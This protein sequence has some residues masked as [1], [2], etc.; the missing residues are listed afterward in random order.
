MTSETNPKDINLSGTAQ[1]QSKLIQIAKIE[2]KNLILSEE[3][4]NRLETPSWSIFKGGNARKSLVHW[5]GRE[6]EITQIKQ[7]FNDQNVAMIGIKGVG[8]IGKSTLASKIFEE[9]I[10][11]APSL[12]DDEDLF[13]KRFWWEAGNLG[14]FSGLAR[15]FLTDFGYPVP[16]KEIDLQEA[17]IRQLQRYSHLIIIDNLESL[18]GKDGSWNNEFYQQFFTAW[19]E[20]GDTSKIIVT[21]REKPKTRGFNR[22]IELKGLKPPEGAQLLAESQITGDLENFSRRVDGHPL[23]LRLVADLILAEFPQNPSLERLADLGLGNL[24]Q[25]LSD[26]QVMGSH[27]QETVGIALVLDASFQRLSQRQQELFTKTSIYRR[28]FDSPAAKAVMD[29]YPEIALSEITADLR[30]LQRRSLLEE[31]EENRQ[32]IFSFQPLVWEYAQYKA[33]DQREL[34]QK[35]I[36][37]YL[38]IAKPDSWETLNDVQPYL[39][40]FYHR[41]QLTDYDNAFDILRPIEDFLTRGGYYQILADYYLQLVTVYQQQEDQTHWNYAASLTSLGNVYYSLGEYQKAIEFHQQ[42]LAIK[43]EI[44]DRGGEGNSYNNLGNVYYSLGEYQKAIEFYQQSLAITREIGDRG[45][46]GKSYNNLGNVYQSLGEYQKALE[47]YQQSLAITREIGDRGGEGK[48]YNNLGTVYNSL[49][50]Y[51]KAIEFHQQSLAI[52]REIGDR[53]DE[54]KSY[55]NLR[56]VYHSLGEYQKAIEFYQQSLAITREIG[57]RGGEGNSYG[58]LGAVYDSLGEYQKAIEFHQQ[59][60]AIKREIGNRGG[61]ASSWFNLGVTYYKLKRIA[62]AKEAYLQ[63]RELYQALGLAADVQDCDDQ[64]R[65][66]ETRKYPLIVAFFLGVVM[67][68]FV[69]IGGIIVALWRLLKRWLRK[70]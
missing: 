31:K 18:L 44:G 68:P 37:Y 36:A 25:L 28:E 22:W 32:R 49:G 15:Q 26:P 35:A 34:H 55:G 64:I 11:L 70:A 58:N 16:E 29:N 56:N 62:E 27:R 7:W 43:R 3:L 8:G 19:I 30:E 10:T 17:L 47:F 20:K 63:S 12:G 4:L 40:I 57:D 39:E 24:S 50:E 14:G 9:K 13:P 60:L 45:G 42:S 66:L 61:E 52:T 46:E 33:G 21:T 1:D 65:Q 23:L 67:F 69:L 41:Y 48:S 5:Q 6:E 51:Q 53:G 38:S 2:T 59:S 54:G